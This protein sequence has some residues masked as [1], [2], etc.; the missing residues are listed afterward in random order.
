MRT[1]LLFLLLIGAAP[2]HA[3]GSLLQPHSRIQVIGDSTF[4]WNAGQ[5]VRSMM[6]NLG[7]QVDDNSAPGAKIT[8]SRLFARL[9]GTDITSVADPLTRDWLVMTG[10]ANDLADE[11]GCTACAGVLDDLISADGLDG[12]IIDIIQSALKLNTQVIYAT[13]YDAPLGGGPL[14]SCT[15]ALNELEARIRRAADQLDGLYV[16]DMGDALNPASPQDYDP[17]RIHPSPQTSVRIAKL[18]T[19]TIMR[20]EGR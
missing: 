14:S 19:D 13:Y 18:I 4:A 7:I 8:A 5:M 12:E 15:P 2:V 11:C 10:G 16:I 20:V 17:D 1:L 6:F 9:L 3:H